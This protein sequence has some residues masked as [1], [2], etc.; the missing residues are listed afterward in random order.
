[1]SLDILGT[2]TVLFLPTGF[3]YREKFVVVPDDDKEKIPL[4]G[5]LRGARSCARASE[6]TVGYLFNKVRKPGFISPILQKS[7]LRPTEIK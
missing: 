7:K 3:P 6:Q 2:R 1:M 4:I 5:C